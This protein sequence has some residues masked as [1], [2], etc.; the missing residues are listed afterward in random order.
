MKI[1]F[2]RVDCS[3]NERK[4]VEEVLAS[5]WLT[6]ASKAMTFEERFCEAVGA[7]HA[8]AVNSCTAGLHLALV[9]AGIGPGDRVLVPAMT[10]TATAEVIRYCDADPIFLEV[11][12]AT[13]VITPEILSAAIAQNPDVKALMVV[14]LGGYPAPLL[15]ANGREGIRDICKKNNITL[16]EDAAHAFPTRC[17]QMSIG[18]IGD[19]TC[20][21]FYA[22]KTITTGE[23]GMI[24]TMDEESASRIKVMR[25]HGISRDIWDRYRAPGGAAWEYDVLAAGFKYNM[26]DV[27]AAI[28]LAQLERGY[29]FHQGRVRCAQTYL[30][31]LK[32]I[33]HVDL[34]LAPP[35]FEAHSWHLFQLRITPQARVSRNV[36][37][38]R[39]S[40]AGIGLSVHYKPLYRMTYYRDRYNLST[41]MFP[42]TEKLWN[43]TV[44]LPIYADLSD[45]EMDYICETIQSILGE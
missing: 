37:I 31:R 35:D 29:E 23:G 36:F 8:Y 28:G 19:Y 12:Y 6:T 26:S 17:G 27:Q 20:F 9:A 15:P 16:I 34:P 2:S 5:G 10:F 18:S 45:T 1:P 30:E 42:E 39:M 25:L 11:D 22:N 43:A 14:H 33:P 4:Y 7:K 21:S 3:G 44:S 24:T 40:E 13:G 38:T 32:N 41:A